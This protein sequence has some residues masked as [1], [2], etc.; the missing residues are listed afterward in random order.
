MLKPSTWSPLDTIAV[1]VDTFARQFLHT[2]A[3]LKET[4]V[5]SRF[6]WARLWIWIFIL[7]FVRTFNKKNFFDC[8]SV[9]HNYSVKSMAIWRSSPTCKKQLQGPGPVLSAPTPPA[10]RP[11]CTSMW[12][13]STCKLKVTHVHTAQ[14]FVLISN[15]WRI[16]K[17]GVPKMRKIWPNHLLDSSLLFLNVFNSKLYP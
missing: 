5:I 10:T 13:Q 3:I 16:T 9:Y 8:I 1:C 15:P 2:K 4:T 7:Y 17:Q 12:R 14:D 11:T 6:M